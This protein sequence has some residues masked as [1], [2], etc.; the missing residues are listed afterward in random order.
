MRVQ[1]YELYDGSKGQILRLPRDAKVAGVRGNPESALSIGCLIVLEPE[2][3]YG[4]KK[5]ERLFF[6]AYTGEDVTPYS[7]YIGTIA[8]NGV[9]FHVF[10]AEI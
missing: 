10:E 9:S 8:S 4:G 7:G 5:E 1:E 3:I 6:T 2:D